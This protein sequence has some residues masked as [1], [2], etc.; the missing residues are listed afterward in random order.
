MLRMGDEKQTLWDIKWQG[1]SSSITL[2]MKSRRMRWV[3]GTHGREEIYIQSFGWETCR[4][5]PLWRPGCDGRMMCKMGTREVGWEDIS[6]INVTLGTS[7]WLLW[8]WYEWGIVFSTCR[9]VGF[10][11]RFVQ[12][13]WE[14][15]VCNS[16]YRSHNVII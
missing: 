13:L 9:P 11:Q 8:R 4:K 3:C 16:S 2:D 15:C 1:I 14:G 5:E 10:L 12:K 7:G 6:W